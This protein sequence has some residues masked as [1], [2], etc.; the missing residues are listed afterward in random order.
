MTRIARGVE[1]LE[2]ILWHAL[3][4]SEHHQIFCLNFL[5]G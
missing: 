5:L 4:F 2:E 1:I 3:V